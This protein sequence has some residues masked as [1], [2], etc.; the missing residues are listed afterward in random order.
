MEIIIVVIYGLALLMVF[1]YSIIQLDL[2]VSYL[3]E[4]DKSVAQKHINWNDSQQIPHVS[5][6]LP[7]YNEKYVV[8]RLIKRIACLDYPLDKLDIQILDD[9]TDDSW[10]LIDSL[11]EKYQQQGVAIKVLRRPDRKGYKAGALKYWLPEAKGEYIAIFDADFLPPKD[12]LKKAL[13]YFIDEDT[14]VV[15]TRWT[16]LNRDYS[17]LTKI[18][19]FALD[20]H[21]IIEQLGRNRSNHFINFNGTAGIWRKSCILDAGNWQGDTLTEDLDLSYR[22]QMKKWKFNYVPDIEAPAE[23]P[24]VLSAARSQQFRWNKGAAENF[25]K[26]FSKLLKTK[27]VTWKTKFHAFFHLLNSSMF[28]IILL[29]AVLSVPILFIKADHP[30]LQYVFYGLAGFVVSTF[31][32]LGCYWASYAKVHG[33]GFKNFFKFIG[34]FLAFFSVAMGFSLHNT[35]AILEGHLGKKSGFIRTP[36]F[37]ID[38][39]GTSLKANQY[40]TTQLNGVQVLEL[41]L[42]LYFG[43][44]LYAAFLVEDFGLFIFHLMLFFGF[45]FVSFGSVFQSLNRP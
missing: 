37:N 14:G 34:M 44:G 7:V 28:L 6:Q 42:F 33:S 35:I 18:Q 9:S 19:A 40:V 39:L 23:I 12:W 2:L 41:V 43:F 1:F 13:P 4:K 36:K 20:F 32:F 24:A 26:N 17:L 5:I 38:K 27:G 3:K 16:H 31:I 15:Q 21:F 8:D 29:I 45:G 11:V 30:E 22:A 10:L 25:K